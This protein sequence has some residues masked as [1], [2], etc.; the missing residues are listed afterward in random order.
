[1]AIL[2]RRLIQLIAVLLIPALLADTSSAAI[3]LGSFHSLPRPRPS[4]F[5]SLIG[6]QALEERGINFLASEARVNKSLVFKIESAPIRDETVFDQKVTEDIVLFDLSRRQMVGLI[7]R[8]SEFLGIAALFVQFGFAQARPGA[9][10]Q[11]HL[12]QVWRRIYAQINPRTSLAPS[13]TGDARYSDWASSYDSAMRIMGHIKTGDLDQARRAMDYFLIHPSIRKNGGWIV[14]TIDAASENGLAIESVAHTGT[15]AYL[16][17]AALHLYEVTNDVKYLNFARERWALIKAIQNDKDPSDPNYGGVHMGPK[18]AEGSPLDQRVEFNPKFPSFYSFYNAEFAADFKALS[19]LLYIIDGSAPDREKYRQASQLVG[20]W[21]KKIFDPA[22][23]LFFWGTTEEAYFDERVGFEQP[24]GLVR[25]HPL[26]ATALKISAYGVAGLDRLLGQGKA[27]QIRKAIDDH[28]KVIVAVGAEGGSRINVTG[29]DFM[30]REERSRLKVPGGATGRQSLLSDEWSTWVAFADLR[31]RDHFEQQGDRATAQA[32]E[33]A[34]SDNARAQALRTA[35]RTPQGLAYAYAQPIPY[36]YGKSA[37]FGWI[38]ARGGFSIIGGI[39][40]SL[41]MLAADPYLPHFGKYAEQFAVDRSAPMGGTA[42]APAAGRILTQPE[43][44]LGEAWKSVNAQQWQQALAM[45]DRMFSEHPNWASEAKTQEKTASALRNPYPVPGIDGTKDQIFQRFAMLYHVG[46]AEFIRAKALYQLAQ[47]QN[48]AGAKKPLQDRALE[49]A[50]AIIRDYPHSQ[51]DGGASFW[52]PIRS[53]AN[54]MPDLYRQAMQALGRRVAIPRSEFFNT[55]W[56]RV[57]GSSAVRVAV[58]ALALLIAP[59]LAQLSFSQ[60]PPRQSTAVR[61]EHVVPWAPAVQ[62]VATDN[63]IWLNI[64]GRLE[65]GLPGFDYQ[66]VPENNPQYRSIYDFHGKLSLLYKALLPPRGA[67]IDPARYGDLL[68]LAQNNDGAPAHDDAKDIAMHGG[69]FIRIYDLAATS[70]EDRR[71]VLRIFRWMYEAYKL[72]FIAGMYDP[73]EWQAHL[74]A[75][76]IAGQPGVLAIDGWNEINLRGATAAKYREIDR[77]AGAYRLM[78][79]NNPLAIVVSQTLNGDD[80]Q[81]L[82]AMKNIQIVSMTVFSRDPEG[83]KRYIAQLQDVLAPK[84]VTLAEIGVPDDIDPIERSKLARGLAVAL[85]RTGEQKP[86]VPYFGWFAYSKEGGKGKDDRWGMAGTPAM[87]AVGEVQ[88]QWTEGPRA[89][90]VFTH[91][92]IPSPTPAIASGAAHKGFTADLKTNYHGQTWY[93]TFV[94]VEPE[95]SAEIR[96]ADAL[97]F[98]VHPDILKNLTGFSVDVKGNG[99]ISVFGLYAHR[100]WLG[101]HVNREDGQKTRAFVVEHP[102]T[103]ELTIVVP[104]NEVNQAFAKYGFD[105]TTQLHVQ[106]GIQRNLVWLNV[107]NVPSTSRVRTL[108]AEEARAIRDREGF[109][110][111]Q[112]MAALVG[113]AIGIISW[114]VLGYRIVRAFRM[115]QD[116]ATLGSYIT[117]GAAR[118]IT[119][120]E[121]LAKVTLLLTAM[122]QLWNVFTFVIVPIIQQRYA[123]A[124]FNTPLVL[125]ITPMVLLITW[126]LVNSVGVLLLPARE[127]TTNTKYYSSSPSPKPADQPWPWVTI[128]IPVAKENF[129]DVIEPTLQTALGAIAR[130]REQGGQANIVVY[131]DGLMR[132]TE[133]VLHPTKPSWWLR[134]N[135]FRRRITADDLPSTPEDFETLLARIVAARGRGDILTDGEAEIWQRVQFYRSHSIGFVAR[136]SQGRRGRFPKSSNLNKGMNL[137]DQL[138]QSLQVKKLSYEDAAARRQGLEQVNR[139]GL[140]AEGDIGI[141]E[142][143]VLLDKDS[144]MPSGAIE[145]TVPE[146]LYDPQLGFTQ[147]CML[148][149]NE[150]DNFVTQITGRYLRN[151]FQL[152]MPVTTQG[153]DHASLMG[154]NAF[155]RKSAMREVALRGEDGSLHYWSETQVAEDFDLLFR[156]HGAGY[157]GRYVAFPGLDFGEGMRRTFSEEAAWIRKIAFGTSNLMFNPIR[158]WSRLGILQKSYRDYLKSRTVPMHTKVNLNVYLISY[159]GFAVVFLAALAQVFLLPLGYVLEVFFPTYAIIILAQ[160]FIISGVLHPLALSIL[161]HR[162]RPFP[163]FADVT[164]H[165]WNAFKKELKTGLK[166]FGFFA[167]LPAWIIQGVIYHVLDL[168]LRF[169]ATN[170]DRLKDRGIFPVMREITRAHLMQIIVGAISIVWL[171][172]AY[173]HINAWTFWGAF[174]ALV[175][176]ALGSTLSPYLYNPLFIKAL[177]KVYDRA[178][179]GFT[180]FAEKTYI[181]PLSRYKVV[182]IAAILLSFPILVEASGGGRVGMG[183]ALFPLLLA[184]VFFGQLSR[185]LFLFSFL[186]PMFAQSMVIERRVLAHLNEIWRWIYAQ[187]DRQTYQAPSHPGDPTLLRWSVVYDDAMRVMGHIQTGR[188]DLAKKTLDYFMSERRI[189]QPNGW[190]MN[191]IDAGTG[192]VKEFVAHTGPNVYLGLAAAHLYEATKEIKYLRFAQERWSLVER[193]QNKD[194]KDFNYGAVPM[195]PRPGPDFPIDP[196]YQWNPEGPSFYQ[197]YNAE[198]NVD[199]KALSDLLFGLTQDQKYKA[200]SDLVTVWDRKIFDPKTKTFFWGTTAKAYHDQ[201]FDFD[202]P[203]GIIPWHPLDASAL[204]LSAY[205]VDGLDNLLRGFGVSSEDFRQAIDAQFKVVVT[206]TDPA[207]RRVTI[208]GYDFVNADERKRIALYTEPVGARNRRRTG[209]GR[210]P[211]A[212]DEWATW[213]AFGDL[214]F[215]NDFRQKRQLVKADRYETAYRQNAVEQALKTGVQ[216]PD[217]IARPYAHPIPYSWN[218][219]VA[220][221]WNT[222]LRP[223][224]SIIGDVARTLGFLASDPFL[225]GFGPLAQK[226][227]IQVAQAGIVTVGGIRRLTALQTAVGKPREAVLSAA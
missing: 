153:G 16:G 93:G 151:L 108:A 225:P 44:Y 132:L 61:T 34:Y 35:V 173:L 201:D 176:L 75:E 107:V 109:T 74:M 102:Q 131:D 188:I 150:R 138:E 68:T 141:G 224:Y 30:T 81:A 195:S 110:P 166:Y 32:Y 212:T 148:P 152:V 130:Y 154:H 155:L 83:L 134:L 186:T 8:A 77:I 94:G 26:D 27:V 21:D 187:I 41:G 161:R 206:F 59:I 128:Q 55:L 227:V 47:Q 17:I 203:V 57:P 149:D 56:R 184:A 143:L 62:P 142:F 165:W 218:K 163:Q 211:L 97:A 127:L 71:Q 196:K 192:E 48:A 25:T 113:M 226:V 29:Y 84:I 6:Q 215:A 179:Q 223:A 105:R 193:I 91:P 185:R 15:N 39:A 86:V 129:S 1:M 123:A 5:V 100:D 60:T 156:M 52:Q 116:G 139:N 82:K 167:G 112:W 42:S 76:D 115:G 66:P 24:V 137:A 103:G 180:S 168:P 114:R 70:Q 147:H 3:V 10:S 73:T 214:R 144:F 125:L 13:H 124:F 2:P 98:D 53:L 159:Y 36:S 50:I 79:P 170:M 209:Q 146:F 31:F 202:V 174:T 200:A 183:S 145:A 49:S 63:G 164:S 80:L 58:L 133:A 204:R 194:P 67:G 37:G 216:T 199:F 189:R 217:G 120:N 158:E 96:A 160:N 46:T 181:A 99:E 119:R 117:A 205:G 122:T 172:F 51:V 197:L 169:S 95:Q 111:F 126:V 140:I 22:T 101:W 220:W 11:A 182:R 171:G 213:V 43:Q 38:I 191:I 20:I 23:N 89:E 19:D 208:D 28:F 175:I 7:V 69:H 33:N 87:E 18:G 198:H 162:L 45:V 177:S 219:P 207:G 85:T 135:P 12:M 54:E 157:F 104:M 9:E 121:K 4:S 64:H 136:P 106:T 118:R 72:R 14:N 90:T 40:R 92:V 65:S 88:R 78:D 178:N 221:G 190:I 210:E 222:P